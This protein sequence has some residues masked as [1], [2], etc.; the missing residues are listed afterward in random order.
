M[1]EFTVLSWT[2]S[3]RSFLPAKRAQTLNDF[4]I[5]TTL[6]LFTVLFVFAF[7]PS[8]FSPFG[9]Q[10]T[11]GDS[12]H[13]DRSAE[14]LMQSVLSDDERSMVL[15]GDCT[16]A[17]FSNSTVGGCSYTPEPLEETLGYGDEFR[18]V[19]ITIYTQD[20]SIVTYNSV[21]LTRGDTPSSQS[22]T[23]SIR[24]IV[25]LDGATYELVVTT[26]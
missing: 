6:F 15:N 18:P 11:T 13:T 12:I 25:S 2:L 7:V 3:S 17:F 10:T 14:H 24:R 8:I 20:G 19:N 21:E 23:S 16:E 22:R 5:G 26:W 1:T 9:L 4:A